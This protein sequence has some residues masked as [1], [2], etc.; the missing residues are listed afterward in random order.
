MGD[1]LSRVAQLFGGCLL[2]SIGIFFVVV[3]LVVLLFA[4]YAAGAAVGIIGL[5]I[6]CVGFIVGRKG[7][8]G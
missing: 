2:S 5:L 7:A 6:L 3:G 4:D 1:I 8:G